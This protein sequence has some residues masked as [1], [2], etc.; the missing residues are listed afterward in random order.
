MLG[1]QG[2]DGESG[3]SMLR[4]GVRG[5]THFFVLLTSLRRI[6]PDSPQ[7]PLEIATSGEVDG[8]LAVKI[9]NTNVFTST[10]DLSFASRVVLNGVP[11][12]MNGCGAGGW[13]PG[14]LAPI[15]PEVCSTLTIFHL[16]EGLAIVA[17]VA[18]FAQLLRKYHKQ[19]SADVKLGFSASDV[20]TATKKVVEAT[21][22]ARQPE[23][24]LEVRACVDRA[25]PWCD[26]VRSRRVIEPSR[27][28]KTGALMLQMRRLRRFFSLQ[29]SAHPSTSCSL[30]PLS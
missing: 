17:R 5:A 8:Q 1:G 3:F 29:N 13:A 16:F 25:L 26:K 12:E 4:C 7:A 9:D 20:A 6:K 23:L 11:L 14:A 28:K 27:A 2:R 19:A 10:A 24:F 21:H 22:S 30:S 15:P 18:H